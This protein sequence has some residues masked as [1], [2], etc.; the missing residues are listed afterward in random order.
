MGSGVLATAAA[1]LGAK[2]VVGV[3]LDF[4][5]IAHAKQNFLVSF[6]INRI[7]CARFQYMNIHLFFCN[8]GI[9]HLMF[10]RYITLLRTSKMAVIVMSAPRQL[11]R[12]EALGRNVSGSF[13]NGVDDDNDV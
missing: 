9:M 5:I 11:L 8:E 4:E 1:L 10:E 7:K 13:S 2:R 12:Q 6:I 3:D